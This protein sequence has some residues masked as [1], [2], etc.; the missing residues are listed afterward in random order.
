MGTGAYDWTAERNLRFML[1]KGCRH[2]GVG[3]LLY[4]A[5]ETALKALIIINLYSMH[6]ISG[7]RR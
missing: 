4:Q 6:W 2:G 7:R 1:K 5:L 3:K